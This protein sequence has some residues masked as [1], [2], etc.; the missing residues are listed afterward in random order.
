MGWVAKTTAFI[1]ERTVRVGEGDE[2]AMRDAIE[3]TDEFDKLVGNTM[4]IDKST[5]LSTT[6]ARKGWWKRLKVDGKT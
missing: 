3:A 1:D 6:E 2:Q 4:N 5:A